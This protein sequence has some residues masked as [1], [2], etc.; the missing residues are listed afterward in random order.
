MHLPKR[1]GDSKIERCPFCSRQ[2]T[3]VNSQTIPVCHEHKNVK[4]GQMKCVCGEMLDVKQGK[5]GTF[6]LCMKCGPQNMKKVF[7]TNI[8]KPEVEV[9]IHG[10]SKYFRREKPGF[11]SAMTGS[12]CLFSPK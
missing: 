7:E 3:T 4:L 6:F 10:D 9:A 12:I 11:G 5:Y 1:Y 8:A 2:S